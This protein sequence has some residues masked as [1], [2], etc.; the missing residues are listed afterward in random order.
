MSTVLGNRL[1]PAAQDVV[2][3]IARLL[4]GAVLIAHGWQKLVDQGVGATADGFAQLGIPAPTAA[5][6]FAVVA[7]LGGGVLLVLG[8]LTPVAGLLVAGTMAGAWWFVHRGS[9]LFAAEGGWELVAAL[10]LGALV[11]GVVPGR[12]ALDHVLAG[13]GAR[14]GP[15]A[16]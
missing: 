11:L 9:G 2:L 12:L 13:R 3:L 16:A 7:E 14:R 5:A 6:V 4:L 15:V 1:P 8:L 10:G